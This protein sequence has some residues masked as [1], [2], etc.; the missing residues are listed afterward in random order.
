MRSVELPSGARMPVYGMGT[1]RMGENPRRR[2]AEADVLRM[3]YPFPLNVRR[4]LRY[5]ASLR[6]SGRPWRLAGHAYAVRDV[7]LMFLTVDVKWNR[8]RSDPRFGD[9]LARCGFTTIG[10]RAPKTIER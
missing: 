3:V 7:H 1:W 9:L 6:S 8:Y 2:T 4:Q 10:T 5:L